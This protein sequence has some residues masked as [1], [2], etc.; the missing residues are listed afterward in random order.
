MPKQ[1]FKIYEVDGEQVEFPMDMSD[2]E[3]SE[4]IQQ[5]AQTSG[6]LGKQRELIEAA[7]IGA[8]ED[9]L[10]GVSEAES[11][12]GAVD[13]VRTGIPIAASAFTMNPVA[14]GLITGLSDLTASELEER[15]EDPA[16]QNNMDFM[17][18]KARHLGQ[19]TVSGGLSYGG[20]RFLLPWANK[21]VGKLKQ[22]VYGRPFLPG[23][24]GRSDVMGGTQPD[25][26]EGQALL[27]TFDPQ[28]FGI[29][30]AS[31]PFS[32][33]LD[34]LN[35]GRKNL[36]STIG[37]F[38]RSSF[39]GGARMRKID[40]RN[41]EV[42]SDFVR[43]FIN[44]NHAT[45]PKQFGQSLAVLFNQDS[46]AVEKGTSHLFQEFRDLAYGKGVNV[47]IKDSF[48]YLIDNFQSAD[49]RDVFAKVAAS[50][51]DF[52][53]K[54]GIGEQ[55]MFKTADEAAQIIKM[56][57]SARANA[58]FEN[59]PEEIPVEA[60]YDLYRMLNRKFFG[61][62]ISGSQKRI[63]GEFKKRLDN[64]M[65]D[66]MSA[67][68]LDPTVALDPKSAQEAA[69]RGKAAYT[70]FREAND[71]ASKNYERTEKR[72]IEELFKK[73]GDE[74]PSAVLGMLS[75]SGGIDRLGALKKFFKTSEALTSVDYEKAVQQPLRHWL[76]SMSVDKKTGVVS[77][78][79]LRKLLDTAEARNGPEFTNEIFGA[80]VTK[81]ARTAAST[82]ELTQSADE[83][84]IVM[85]IIQAG[86]LMSAASGIMYG[87]G[88][89]IERIALG[90][91]GVLFTPWAF[92]RVISNPRLM[93]TITDG[94]AKGTG[95][96]AF[97][98]AVL[99]AITQNRKSIKEMA[100]LSPEAQ[101]FYS[102]MGEE[103]ELPD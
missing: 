73:I 12:E 9:L 62:K 82:L 36:S 2:Q 33:P 15:Y 76:L 41:E 96:S 4:V 27:G 78:A 86:A 71:F 94:F 87:M 59:M 83:S 3:I 31:T 14:L 5:T 53:D 60:A 65:K 69:Q 66:G 1:E 61:K 99:V 20:D 7:D 55:V 91:F 48:K 38:A 35:T 92:S 57:P 80:D 42:L 70:K 51:P 50:N 102:N 58:V 98:R 10:P 52:L 18:R 17:K 28:P 85:K 79:K 72:I 37:T 23:K 67:I 21:V 100:G 43:S 16:Y 39:G 95:S 63:A 25:V 32:L 84:N 88:Q 8:G 47:N 68:T 45:T 101:Q 89:P 77:G 75:G 74:K 26:R 19:A 97:Q 11:H 44:A 22:F 13:V 103:L 46:L 6:E 30:E 56:L 29:R 90:G 24:L 81:S 54:L 64:A 93:R 49:A 34:Q 40:L